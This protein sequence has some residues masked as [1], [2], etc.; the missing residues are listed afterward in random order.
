MNTRQIRQAIQ[1]GQRVLGTMIVS[2]SPH[3]PPHIAKTG[4]DCVFLDTEHIALDRVTLSWMCRTYGALN[5]APIVRIPHPDPHAARQAIDGGAVGIVAPYLEE[6]EEV[7]ALRGA[8]KYRPLKGRK[9]ARVLSGEENLPAGLARYVR[10]YN[11]DNLLLINIESVPAMENLDRLLA[12]PDLDGILIGPHDLS[13]NLDIP[14]QYTHAR[15]RKAMETIVGKTRKKGLI[16]GIHFMGCGP[17][18][19]ALDWMRMGINL[20]IQ[21]A[22][23]YYVARGVGEDIRAIRKGLGQAGSRGRSK[24]II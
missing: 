5:L 3:W 19:L 4:C 6:V 9:L 13:C 7:Q 21:H 14:E 8:V 1:A 11:R 24:V 15:F 2:P 12:V 17:V 18:S 10:E 23:V 20:H 16:A 22:D